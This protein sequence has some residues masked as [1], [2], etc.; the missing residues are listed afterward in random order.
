MAEVSD[1]AWPLTVGIVVFD[2]VEVLDFAGPFEVFSVTR[3]LDADAS[4]AGDARRLFR[5]LTLA[6]PRSDAAP[7]APDPRTVRCRNGLRVTADLLIGT[8]EIPALDVLLVPGGYGTR[9]EVHSAPLIAWLR[10]TAPAT[11][12]I[13]SSVCTGAFLLA[14]AGLLDGLGATTHWASL[15]RMQAAYPQVRVAGASAGAEARPYGT[16]YVDEGR[17]VTSAGI[18]AGIDMAL[19]LV[20]RLAGADV[21]RQ[22]A[23]QM[24]YRWPGEG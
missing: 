22:T 24:E 23:E 7:A 3:P 17:V 16:R 4:P 11:R 5:V 6:A 1:A 12:H 21:A 14:E 10:D 9:R 13:V 20:A 2:D 19:H 18:S 8:D 15:Q